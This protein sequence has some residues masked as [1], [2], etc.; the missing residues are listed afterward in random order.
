MNLLEAIDDPKLFAPWFRDRKSWDAWLTFIAAL[1]GLGIGGDEIKLFKDCTGRTAAPAS[2]FREAWLVCG[3]RSG[4]SF[5]LALIAT[6]LACFCNYRQYLV[7][8]EYATVLVVAA[9]RR[10]ARIILGYI[11]GMLRGIPML[12]RMMAAETKESFELNNGV[13]IEISTASFRS[14]RGYALAAFLA[15]ELAFWRSDDSASPDFE[16]LRAVRPAMLT[17]PTAML[18]CASSPYAR[19]GALYEAFKQH[20]GK[21]DAPALVWRADTLTMNPTVSKREIEKEYELDPENAKAE[22]GAE[23]RSDIETFLSRERVMACVKSELRERPPERQW[24]YAA[25]VDPSGGSSDSMTLAIAHKEN[26]TVILDLVIEKPSPFSPEAVV[27]EFC[28]ALKRYRC[29]RVVG[30][31]YAG[32]WPREQFRQRGIM[33]DSAEKAKSDLYLDLLPLINSGA[34]DLL[35]HARLITQLTAL[36]RRTRAGGRD[37]IDHPPGAKDDVANAAAGALVQAM[38]VAGW[39]RA[40]GK[41][42]PAYAIDGDPLTLD[43]YGM[44][45]PW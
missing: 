12:A 24:S 26:V 13:R 31:R 41:Q 40:T 4:K 21:D 33:Y 10:Q 9:D 42:E 15:D 1:F 16:V 43:G 7:P 8:G 11:G 29:R 35:D 20:Y 32:E 6:Y 30:D 44:P 27:E 23:F 38:K 37:M 5:V 19:R 39:R 45:A 22:F 28:D 2:G 25:F 36:E 14:V 18:L 3:R 17:I 34:A